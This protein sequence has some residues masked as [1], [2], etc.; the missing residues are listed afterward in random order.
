MRLFKFQVLI[1][2]FPQFQEELALFHTEEHIAR[3]CSEESCSSSSED[4]GVH[5][6]AMVDDEE[7]G[8][9]LTTDLSIG[10]DALKR[11]VERA[12]K[13]S[14]FPLVTLRCGGVGVDSDTVWNP[15][16]TSRSARLA[17]GQVLCLAHQ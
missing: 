16:T 11:P 1:D 14:T 2:Q 13:R 6:R 10:T 7:D 12:T 4:E 5:D 3:F 15:E 17:V 8:K 9:P